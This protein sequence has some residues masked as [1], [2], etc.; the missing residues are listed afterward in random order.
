[1]QQNGD[2]LCKGIFFLPRLVKSYDLLVSKVYDTACGSLVCELL[3]ES[4]I[5]IRYL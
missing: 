1:M 5:I 2:G 3:C 4:C